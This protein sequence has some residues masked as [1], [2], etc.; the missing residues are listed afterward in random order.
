M[1]GIVLAGGNGTRLHPLTL[2]VSK[3]MLPVYDKPMI[4][5][6]IAVLMQTGIREILVIS[7]PKDLPGFQRLLGHG[8]QFGVSFSYLEQPSPGGL[9]QAFII[10]ERF[11]GEG[12]VCMV[13]GDNI[14]YGEGF[15]DLLKEAAR[16]RSGATNFCCRVAD[17]KQF[18]V[19][20]LDKYGNVV[21]IEEKP[22]NPK[23]KWA[24]TGLY[25]YDNHV[26]EIAKSVK[27][28]RRNEMEITDVNKVYLGLNE[29]NVSL[30]DEQMGW[31]DNGTFDSYS[32]ANEAI[33]RIE[34]PKKH[35]IGCLEEIGFQN[36]WLSIEDI[37]LRGHLFEQT[38]YGQYLLSLVD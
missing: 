2:G 8:D 24:S 15:A 36:G 1:R 7:T 14:F 34:K 38:S 35:K 30:L 23:S 22:E 18:G 31:H 12:S 10:G 25:F 5:Y 26:I 37:E 3:H 13:L 4:Y 28:S 33:R 20:E 11:I 17:P 6:P 32:K 19:I 29:L 21:S 9:A 27:P 16:T